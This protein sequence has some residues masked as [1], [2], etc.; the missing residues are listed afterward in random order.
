M[1]KIEYKKG[2]ANKARIAMKGH[3]RQLAL[4]WINKAG[5]VR[6]HSDTPE[7]VNNYIEMMK[8]LK[9]ELK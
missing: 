7:R 8:Y 1:N 9:G 5:S 2:C 6:E 4:D 3:N